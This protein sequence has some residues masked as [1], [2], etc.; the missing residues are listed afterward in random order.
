MAKVRNLII[1]CDGTWNDT[2]SAPTNVSKLISAC[3]TS[4]KNKQRVHYEE[5]VGTAHWE[6]LP[7]GIYGKG[8][9]PILFT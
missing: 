2:K 6:A 9:D 7:G 5:G 4:K 8:L 1:G 3:S